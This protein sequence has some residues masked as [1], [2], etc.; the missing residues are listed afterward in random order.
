MAKTNSTLHNRA[1][2]KRTATAV[3]RRTFAA[4]LS[5]A[6]LCSGMVFAPITAKAAT[7]GMTEHYSFTPSS[8]NATNHTDLPSN[9]VIGAKAHD[10]DKNKEV[11]LKARWTWTDGQLALP[12]GLKNV[13][14][15]SLAGGSSTGSL[16]TKNEDGTY[17]YTSDPADSD[18]HYGVADY[19]TYYYDKNSG[20]STEEGANEL[21]DI[22]ER[23]TAAS[24]NLKIY[25]D[26]MGELKTDGLAAANVSMLY[27][28]TTV[29][30]ANNVAVDRV[31]EAWVTLDDG[32]RTEIVDGKGNVVGFTD[33][34]EWIGPVKIRS[35]TLLGGYSLSVSAGFPGLF[36]Q[37][38]TENLLDIP[39]V[40]GNTIKSI[41]IMPHGTSLRS[42]GTVGIGG[43]KV[44]TYATQ[45][46]FDTCVPA[47]DIT[48]TYVGED[49]LRAIT[50]EEAI[51]TATTE[52]TTD[53]TVHTTF[54]SSDCYYYPT[55]S[56]SNWRN[57]TLTVTHRGPTYERTTDSTR[58]LFQSQI[59][60][61]KY[62][63][64]AKMTDTL[65]DPNSV[66]GMD[67][68]TFVF[69]AISRVSR[70]YAWACM[71]T[72]NAPY[73]SIV[74]DHLVVRD[75]PHFT[76]VDVKNLNS[77]QAMYWAYAQAQAGDI[78]DYYTFK[79]SHTRI[80]K[81]AE[82]AYVDVGEGNGALNKSGDGY[83]WAGD[84]KGRYNID[85]ANS[86]LYCAE[87][88]SI[89]RY[90]FQHKT[91]GEIKSAYIYPSTSEKY[92]EKPY[93]TYSKDSNYKLLYS[94]SARD[95]TPARF[96]SLYKSAYVPFTLDEYAT[97]KVENVRVQA[98]LG[99]T[100][101]G[102]S[103]VNGTANLA[104]TSN[105]RIISYRVELEDASGSLLLDA[106]S[107]PVFDSG[108]KYAMNSLTVAMNYT[109]SKLNAA[110]RQLPA[111]DY[112]LKL[113]VDSG[114]FTELGQDTVPPTEKVF[115]FSV[116]ETRKTITEIHGG[117]VFF[118]PGRAEKG[119]TVLAYVV[120][121]DIYT[122]GEAV[123]LTVPS[124]CANA[125]GWNS[126][127]RSRFW[128]VNADGLMERVVAVWQGVEA[129]R[130][131]DA[132]YKKKFAYHDVVS[133]Y[134]P[135]SDSAAAQ[136]KIANHTNHRI[137]FPGNAIFFP[138]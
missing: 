119:H 93:T 8:S 99:S 102:Q 121:S 87:E 114:P 113:T 82:V 64:P 132:A 125:N 90:Y 4:L 46:D 67:C 1:E 137:H 124:D 65:A 28:F 49:T 129:G 134:T 131:G 122:V 59:K 45:S 23:E 79:G 68:Q 43:L 84:G 25:L 85:P 47:D 9:V 101:A 73:T 48:Y 130:D 138:I 15:Y 3:V 26:N 34:R 97:G 31:L 81:S 108:L 78:V 35:A 110:L 27:A 57:Q 88:A 70:T 123:Y 12:S 56:G 14:I 109:S 120:D 83:V 72:I 33:D 36:Y 13:V 24:E 103:F 135:A 133:S 107:E 76:D 18:Y 52:W 2:G 60:N 44:N 71:N 11:T 116:A 37:I 111:G 127:S 69:N 42:F 94:C 115:P 136:L 74:G 41:K 126:Q 118:I 77:E 62:T 39:G 91:T 6:M 40:K 32:Q 20:V 50:V 117:D 17:T 29:N 53:Y 7:E 100:E 22:T 38:E 112:R 86:Y 75:H 63:G 128:T 96:S 58:E 19:R 51:R 61:G 5:A 106:N 95:N 16:Q 104:F 54:G 10:Y 30:N 55:V 92:N 89:P 66:F 80:V 98:V 21:A 105:Y